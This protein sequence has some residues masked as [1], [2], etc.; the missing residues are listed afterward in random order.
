MATFNDLLRLARHSGQLMAE[1]KATGVR[2][3]VKRR[4]LGLYIECYVNGVQKSE[5]AARLVQDGAL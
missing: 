5:K 3:V 1:D 2:V 4:Q